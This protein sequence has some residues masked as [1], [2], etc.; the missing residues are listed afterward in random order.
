MLG[1]FGKAPLLLLTV[2]WFVSIAKLHGERQETVEEQHI[3]WKFAPSGPAYFCAKPA[4]IQ[5][6]DRMNDLICLTPVSPLC[7]STAPQE[8]SDEAM[9]R[10]LTREDGGYDLNSAAAVPDDTNDLVV[11]HHRIIPIGAVNLG[12]EFVDSWYGRPFP[13]TSASVSIDFATIH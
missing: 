9:M 8:S 10:L 12:F 6:D 2:Y 4:V 5:V 1:V 13:V 11:E 7:I 3:H